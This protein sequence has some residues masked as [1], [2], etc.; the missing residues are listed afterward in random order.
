MFSWKLLGEV[1]CDVLLVWMLERAHDVWKKYKYNPTESRQC[2]F[3]GFALQLFDGLHWASL[4]VVFSDNT[5]T[6]FHPAGFIDLC[7]LDFVKKNA[8][9][10][11]CGIPAA[12]CHFCRLVP[13]GGDAKFLLE[14][15]FGVFLVDWTVDNKD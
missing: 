14:F 6:L 15:M 8:S 13:V 3:I 1:I 12:S 9:K 11:L 5:L 7:L 10:N 4:I 2:T